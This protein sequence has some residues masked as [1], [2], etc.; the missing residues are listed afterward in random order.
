MFVGSVA[1]IMIRGLSK[2]VPLGS[3]DALILTGLNLSALN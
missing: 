2:N 3:L 1:Y